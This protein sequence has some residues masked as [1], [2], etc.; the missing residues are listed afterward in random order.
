MNE[1]LNIDQWLVTPDNPPRV[2]DGLDYERCAALHN[3]L[4]QYAW[5][6]SNRDLSDLN[7]LS[8]FEK[9]G[10]AAEI[11]QYLEPSLVKFLETAYDCDDSS[12]ICPF[13]WVSTFNF[14]ERLW[15]NWKDS[16]EI[17]EEHRRLTLY[18]THVGLLGGHTDGLC[19]DQKRHKAVMFMSTDD[20][21]YVETDEGAHL[22]DPLE[23]VLSNW[24]FTLR[25]GKITAGPEGVKL[26]N[27]RY[28]PWMYHS[29][30]YQQ[31][32][33][34]VAAFNRLV[35]T[36]ESR[37]PAARRRWPTS[38]PVLSHKILDEASVPNPSFARSFL[39]SIR[40]P[41]FKF[42]GPGL[43]VLS[44]ETFVANQCFTIIHDEDDPLAIPPVLL[45]RAVETVRLD[46]DEKLEQRNLFGRIYTS[47]LLGKA[48]PAGVYTDAI[49]RG[50][51]DTAEEGFRLV[52]PYAIGENGFAR[53]SDGSLIGDDKWK[54]LY[55]HG[56]KPF[57]GDWSRA[58]RLERLFDNWMQMVENGQWEV[59]DDG[60]VGGIEKFKEADTEAHWKDY[61][62][63]PDW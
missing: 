35:V 34:T 41:S 42:I 7:S 13:Y 27:E 2:I 25:K 11:R 17:G 5:V 56:G 48:I 50:Q 26:E 20:R 19:Y 22:W 33:D 59:D 6:A 54:D 3:Y 23:I 14:P 1:N 37:I 16:G 18:P 32:E 21:G 31:V 43:Q 28:G 46:L 53:Q 62:I 36:I 52:L 10:N 29:Y 61:W 45:F 24:I 4:I 55:Q 39:A 12:G 49:S 30:S 38:T 8:W 47:A 60:V 40:L 51:P 63:E 57:G 44:P 9:H 58:Q 15:V